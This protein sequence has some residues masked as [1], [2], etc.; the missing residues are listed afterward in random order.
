[1]RDIYTTWLTEK[2]GYR[3]GCSEITEKVTNKT[4][5]RHVGAATLNK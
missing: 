5:M 3:N 4:G 2:E 1:M